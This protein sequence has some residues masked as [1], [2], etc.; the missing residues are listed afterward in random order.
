MM[1][2]KCGA[3]WILPADHHMFVLEA[4]ITLIATA[5]L[6]GTFRSG[7]LIL[8]LQ[9]Q[10]MLH[11]C[12]CLSGRVILTLN[13]I[14]A[15]SFY[16]L[17]GECEVD[18][19][20]LKYSA[21]SLAY[22]RP[23]ANANRHA[24]RNH[25]FILLQKQTETQKGINKG[26]KQQQKSPFW[27]KNVTLMLFWYQFLFINRKSILGAC[28]VV[29]EYPCNL[30]FFHPLIHPSPRAQERFE[31]HAW[32]L[33]SSGI[34]LHCLSLCLYHTQSQY[35]LSL[36]KSL[37]DGKQWSFHWLSHIFFLNSQTI[38]YQGYLSLSLQSKVNQ[39]TWNPVT[40]THECRL[41]LQP[42]LIV[43]VKD[44]T[45]DTFT[46]GEIGQANSVWE[47]YLIWLVNTKCIGSVN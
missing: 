1:T 9:V 25:F 6:N 8:L 14:L 19:Y 3:Q 40:I 37:T 30:W 28:M 33:I 2:K 35:H 38:L 45:A 5:C 12:R 20:H 18:V 21:M 46:S 36:V 23:F 43:D 17:V 11:W 7:T 44:Q 34:A 10:I 29:C 26:S 41:P 27:M 39:H 22:T 15:I 24:Q 42:A 47:K 13:Y 4:W 31:S 32:C 16:K